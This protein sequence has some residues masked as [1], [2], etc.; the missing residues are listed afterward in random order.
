MH[1][2]NSRHAS[3][4]SEFPAKRGFSFE[5]SNTKTCD[6][7]KELFDHSQFSFDSRVDDYKSQRVD[8]KNQSNDNIF[9][10]HNRYKIFSYKRIKSFVIEKSEHNV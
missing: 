6:N 2:K 10:F 3:K 4:Q 5:I 9:E 1:K 7:Q 8:K